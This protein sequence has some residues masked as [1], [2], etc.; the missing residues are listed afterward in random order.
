VP[1]VTERT[2]H[3]QV[4]GNWDRHGRAGIPVFARRSTAV[5]IMTPLVH[6]VT[7]AGNKNGKKVTGRRGREKQS[8]R[9]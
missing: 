2:R 6:S 7:E 8:K 4:D 1:T 9:I 5:T 3:S